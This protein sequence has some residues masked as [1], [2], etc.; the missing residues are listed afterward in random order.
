[1]LR[2][3]PYS[4]RA[5]DTALALQILEKVEDKASAHVEYAA[6]ARQ[7]NDMAAYRKH[8]DAAFEIADATYEEDGSNDYGPDRSRIYR[9]IISTLINAGYVEDAVS[10]S[11][12]V[13]TTL[14]DSDQEHWKEWFDDERFDMV[15]EGRIADAR[16]TAA[17]SYHGPTKAYVRIAEIQRDDGDGPGATETLQEALAHVDQSDSPVDKAYCFSLI[18]AAFAQMET[19]QKPLM[20]VLVAT[21]LLLL[22]IRASFKSQTTWRRQRGL[23]SNLPTHPPFLRSPK[24]QNAAWRRLTAS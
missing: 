9:D 1:M 14:P 8:M 6:A 17:I 18:A 12:R 15:S 21:K 11:L 10:I 5:R 4:V 19:A 13:S 7:S 2:L 23:T 20:R 3:L 22:W 16:C 24:R